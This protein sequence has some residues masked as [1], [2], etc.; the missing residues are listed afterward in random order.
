MALRGRSEWWAGSPASRGCPVQV[1]AKL[2]NELWD[3]FE[4]CENSAGKNFHFYA[5]R[6]E[7]S[8][9]KKKVAWKKLARSL[10]LRKKVDSAGPANWC[11]VLIDLESIKIGNFSEKIGEKSDK[12]EKSSL[13][14]GYSISWG[15]LVLVA[16]LGGVGGVRGGNFS[17]F[18]AGVQCYSECVNSIRD[19]VFPVHTMWTSFPVQ[20]ANRIGRIWRWICGTKPLQRLRNVF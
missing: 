13:R 5:V 10:K 1:A 19:L 18:S 8:G 9:G 3:H 6:S 4:A 12:K 14:G 20:I 17:P 15:L 11:I 7:K 16:P 2:C